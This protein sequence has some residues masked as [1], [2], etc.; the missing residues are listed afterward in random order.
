MKRP[1]VRTILILAVCFFL[2]GCR[3]PSGAAVDNT[4]VVRKVVDG[5]TVE[6]TNARRVRYTGID[7]PETMRKGKNQWEFAPE[8]YGVA[9][10]D[11]NR[12]L[13]GGREVRL[14]FDVVKEDKYGR[15]LAYVYSGDNMV[16]LELVREGYAHVYTFPPNIKYYDAFI[17][18]QEKA[19]SEKKGIWGQAIDIHPNTAADHIGEY[20]IVQGIV[21]DV[22]VSPQKI[23]L[24][25]GSE[26][27]RY[28]SAVIFTRN[29]PLFLS[30]GIDPVTLYRSRYVEV[31]GKIEE[32]G[33]PEM[34]I[35]NPTQIKVISE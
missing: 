12:S 17:E 23:A 1:V 30:Q 14:E 4:Y 9:A 8:V 19:M 34:I 24:N 10:K 11:H 5:D 7:T 25:F 29:I 2:A 15:W 21:R 13:V 16:N 27:E 3:P 31:T 35:D 20:A 33:G 32:H 18:A 22:F 6:L 26:K 28:L